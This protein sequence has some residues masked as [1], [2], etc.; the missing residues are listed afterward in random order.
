[1]P[2]RDDKDETAFDD[3]VRI[4]PVTGKKEKKS[5]KSILNKKGKLSRHEL[6]EI[7]APV[8]GTDEIFLED[9]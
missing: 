2:M 8:D 9:F 3:E 1:M 4:C 7:F 5:L 6:D